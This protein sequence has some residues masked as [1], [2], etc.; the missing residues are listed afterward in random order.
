MSTT[1]VLPTRLPSYLQAL[2]PIAIQQIPPMPMVLVATYSPPSHFIESKK[3]SFINKTLTP[4]EYSL[5]SLILSL[6][7]AFFFLSTLSSPFLLTLHSPFPSFFYFL[8]S[9]FPLSLT[10]LSI[11]LE[12]EKKPKGNY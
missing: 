4:R 10:T 6:F 8:L 12:R 2:I 1:R 7:P 11:S 5:F 9:S 3:V